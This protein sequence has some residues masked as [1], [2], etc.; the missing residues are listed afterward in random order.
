MV[1][2][3][4][5]AAPAKRFGVFRP[6]RAF[7]LGLLFMATLATAGIPDAEGIIHGC[8]NQQNGL[9]RIVDD[10]NTCRG[11]E[12]KI[13]WNAEGVEGMKGDKGDTGD[14]GPAGPASVDALSGT[15]CIFDGAEGTVLYAVD[16]NGEIRF[17]CVVGGRNDPYTQYRDRD[18]DGFGT[19]GASAGAPRPLAG[20]ADKAGDCDDADPSRFPG[21]YDY[22][23]QIDDDC[24]GDTDEDFRLVINEVDYDQEGTDSAEFIELKNIGSQPVNTDGVVLDLMNK[25]AAT[26]Y[27]TIV[28]SGFTVPPGGYLL[29]DEDP[30]TPGITLPPSGDG[31]SIQ[32]GDSDGMALVLRAT[33]EFKLDGLA[34]DGP[35]PA[36][37]GNPAPDDA[38]TNGLSLSRCPDGMDSDNNAADFR[39]R[40]RTPGALNNC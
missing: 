10:P 26:P 1:G 13:S 32:N 8:Y 37:E 9:L 3:P 21:K 28:L 27:R 31:S 6:A 17:F 22:P 15:P 11:P 12:E 19:D 4:Q 7:V 40:P 36:G 39:I 18:G 24:D 30:S 34:Y 14:Q 16:G 2:E 25:G 20:Y 23:N 5:Q 35:N 29:I 33:P 38:D